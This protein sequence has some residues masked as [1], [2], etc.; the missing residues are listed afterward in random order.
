MNCAS[1][2]SYIGEVEGVYEET[3]VILDS[4]GEKEQWYHA[5]CLPPT[6]IFPWPPVVSDPR[7]IQTRVDDA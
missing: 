1:C 6:K 4:G 3:I 2:G 7:P 5:R